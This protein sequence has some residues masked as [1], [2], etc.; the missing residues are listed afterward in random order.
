M[1]DTVDSRFRGN[2]IYPQSSLWF[3]SIFWFVRISSFDYTYINWPGFLIK[4]FR[5]D[6][7]EGRD[8]KKY[9]KVRKM[10]P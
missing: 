5:N 1:T 7:K 8:D 6:K 9:K 10:D 2:D 4:D 3:V